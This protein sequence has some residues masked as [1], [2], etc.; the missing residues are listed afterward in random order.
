MPRSKSSGLGWL[1][2]ILL[3]LVAGSA[4]ADDGGDTNDDDDDD[5]PDEGCAP[6]ERRDLLTGEC[7]PRGPQSCP[8]GQVWNAATKKCELPG[9]KPDEPTGPDEGCRPGERRD[10][11]TGECI[12]RGPQDCPPGQVW[13]PATRK[14]ELEAPIDPTGPDP[15]VDDPSIIKTYPTPASMYQ[16][17]SNNYELGVAKDYVSSCLYLAALEAGLDHNAALAFAR[18]N[19]TQQAR[20]RAVEFWSCQPD[21]DRDFGTYAFIHCTGQH[22]GCTHPGA[23]GR[24]MRFLKVHGNSA[25][26]MK[27]RQKWRRTVRLGTPNAAPSGWSALSSGE[28]RFPFFY[29]PE[30]DYAVLFASK[31]Q[32]WQPSKKTWADGSS[33][34]Q[35]PPKLRALGFEDLSDAPAGTKWGC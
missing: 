33:K 28:R 26:R 16:V 32:T 2:A 21:N 18:D 13:N 10:L 24:G 15:D 14:C 31:G 4:K 19:N 9:V 12:P 7:V 25:E 17:V 23:N 30:P 8:P 6:G 34:Y 35:R 20:Y 27:A 22:G 29:L 11:F 5:K 3:L 1:A